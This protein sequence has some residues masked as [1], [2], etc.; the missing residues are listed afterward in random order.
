MLE[1]IVTSVKRVS[2]IIAAIAAASQEQSQGIDQVNKAVTQMDQVVQASSAHTE[3]LSSTA[4]GLAAQ[5]QQLQVLVGRFKLGEMVVAAVVPLVTSEDRFEG[6]K[7]LPVGGLAPAAPQASGARV[8][9]GNQTLDGA[10][11]GR[12]QGRGP[13]DDFEPF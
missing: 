9:R 6:Q 3:E 11:S 4:Q 12:D 1:E 13:D 10:A 8:R 5:T 7:A 2:D